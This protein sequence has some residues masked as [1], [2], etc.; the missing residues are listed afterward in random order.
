MKRMLTHRIRLTGTAFGLLGLTLLVQGAVQA[1]TSYKIQ[2]ILKVGETAGDTL[3]PSDYQVLVGGLTDS[4]Q[5]ILGVGTP[6]GSKPEWLLQYADGKITPIVA[7]GGDAPT[8]KWPHDVLMAWPLRMNQRGNVVFVTFRIQDRLALGTYLWDREARKVTPVILKGM[9]A[10]ENLT[11]TE[12]G[13]FYPAINNRDEMALVAVVRDPHGSSGLG[14]FFRGQDSTLLPILAPGQALPG[15]GKVSQSNRFLAPWLSLNDAGAVAFLLR[16]GGEAQSG[17]YVWERGTITP[18]VAIGAAAPGSGKITSV[19]QVLVNN[20]NR[21]VVLAAGVDASPRHG[22]YRYTDGKLMPVAVPGQALPGGGT[23]RSL[24]T[25]ISVFPDGIRCYAISDANDAGEHAFYAELEDGRTAAYRMAADGT[26]SLILKS[27]T[28][29][30]LGTITSVGG[31]GR[32]LGLNTQGQVA[33][34]VQIDGGLETVVLL[35]PTRP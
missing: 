1:Q 8:G 18:L 29:T 32:G 6:E 2:P 33:L 16:R 25:I 30:H 9:P 21:Q 15:G 35:T 23:F 5:I 7:P 10:V 31:F 28:T 22:V 27:G 17:A 20:R 19:S 14:L 34:T 4:G 24:Q 3:I 26:L 12:P 11:F 13:G